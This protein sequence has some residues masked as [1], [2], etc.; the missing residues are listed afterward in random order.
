[1]G[2]LNRASS[3]PPSASP[4]S[5]D[6]MRRTSVSPSA[7]SAGQAVVPGVRDEQ[8]AVRQRDR[9]RGEPQR[10]LDGCRRDVRAVTAVQR[11]R[12]LVLRDELLDEDLD[13]APV[14]LAGHL[15]DD[16]PLGVDHH[17][18]RPGPRGVGG[19]GDAARGRRGRGGAPRTARPPRRG[20]PGRP[21][22]RTSASARR[23]SPARRGTAPRASRSSS[24]TCRQLMQQ[25]VQKSSTTIL[26]RRSA[27]VTDRAAGVQ[28]PRRRAG[29]TD[30]GQPTLTHAPILRRP[31][32]SVTETFQPP[33]PPGVLDHFASGAR[34]NVQVVFS[35]RAPLALRPWGERGPRDGGRCRATAEPGASRRRAPASDRSCD[36]RGASARAL[37]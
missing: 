13:V 5:P 25:N 21:R 33:T 24:R 32:G 3:G 34:R 2:S 29:R 11:A 31:S 20:R 1:M 18:R 30:P 4:R 26:P 28:P 27:S 22:A 10:A 9:L 15:R 12:G 35:P 8:V 7:A 14:P 19:P 16:V 6:P 36:Q 17:E 37:A 23:R